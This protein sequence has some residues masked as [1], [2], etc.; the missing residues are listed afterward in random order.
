M[1]IVWVTLGT[2][3]TV[4]GLLLIDTFVFKGMSDL[5]AEALASP[6]VLQALSEGA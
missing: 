1:M 5:H 6:H 3:A 4:L 2:S